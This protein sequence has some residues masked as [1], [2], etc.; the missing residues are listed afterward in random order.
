[1]IEAAKLGRMKGHSPNARAKQAEEQRRHAAEL[2][3]WNPSDKPNWLTEE[4]YRDK[5]Q[6]RLSNIIVSTIAATLGISE[7]YA[8]AVRAG[9]Y[10][11]HPRH[12]K[13][14]AELAGVSD[15]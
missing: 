9:R 8:A 15:R 6:P 12:W 10:L 7:P 14:L 1:M 13:P 11:P 4:V 3:S 5:I 2:K